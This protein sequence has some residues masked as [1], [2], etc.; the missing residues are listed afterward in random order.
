M[1]GYDGASS[2]FA[3][4]IR[5]TKLNADGTPMI[6]TGNAYVSDKLVQA[7][8]GLNY[9]EAD[10]ITQ[11]NGAGAV[12]ASFQAPRTLREGSLNALRVCGPDPNLV[13]FLIGGRVYEDAEVPPNQI[14]YGAPE[15]GTNP[16]PN[17]VSIEFWSQAIIGSAV[18]NLLPYLHWVC[19]RAYVV[20][21]GNWALNQ[22]AYTLPEFNGTLTQNSGWG[23]GPVGDFDYPSERVWQY[24]RKADLPTLTPGFVDVVADVP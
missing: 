23:D 2:L 11:L 8:L 16:V 10:P 15:T 18:A 13:S 12:C 14:G 4:G 17:G 1:A 6:G 20:P 22:T 21:T 7:E 5:V 24:V 3:L 19:P 9:Q